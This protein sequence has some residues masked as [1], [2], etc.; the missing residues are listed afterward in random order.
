MTPRGGYW[1]YAP[2]SGGKKIPALVQ[3]DVIKRINQVAQELY[4]GRYT[5]LDIHFRGKFCYID[6]YTEPNLADDWPP[7]DWGET[8]EEALECLGNSPIHLCRLRYIG[9]DEW[10]FA[11]YTYSQEKYEL[12][13]YPNGEFTGKPEDAFLASAVYLNN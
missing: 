8:H 2:D 7:A 12:S 1:V 9:N 13:I 5:R 3:A 4:A 11:F 6:A 10:G